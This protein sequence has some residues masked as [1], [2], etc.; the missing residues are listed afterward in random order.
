MGSRIG[1]KHKMTSTVY[2]MQTFLMKYIED[3]I[4]FSPVIH[5]FN[6][7]SQYKVTLSTKSPEIPGNYF[8]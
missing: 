2:E 3:F 7:N 1:D 5:I 8:L 6:A 4:V